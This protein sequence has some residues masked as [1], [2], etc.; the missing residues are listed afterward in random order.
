MHPRQPESPDIQQKLHELQRRYPVVAGVMLVSA[1]G[2]VLAATFQK[3]DSVSR[4]AAVSRT[5]Y[6][7]AQQTCHEFDRGQMQSVHLS[8]RWAEPGDDNTPGRVMIRPVNAEAILVLVL[9]LSTPLKQPDTLF[10]MDIERMVGY[11]AHQ[12][13]HDEM[14]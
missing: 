3:E 6:L 12:I 7:L 4:L 11:L 13:T 2:L 5:M 10:Q 9:H 8:F 1:G 14:R